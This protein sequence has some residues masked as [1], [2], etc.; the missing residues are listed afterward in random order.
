MNN[1]YKTILAF[2]AVIVL[3]G[4]ILELC[5][6]NQLRYENALLKAHA[7]FQNNLNNFLCQQNN[8]LSKLNSEVVLEN[9]F[10]RNTQPNRNEIGFNR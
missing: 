1:L 9:E 4:L 7:N 6:I 8:Q 5:K 10:L 3:V 2:L